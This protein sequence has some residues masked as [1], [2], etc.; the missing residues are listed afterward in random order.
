MYS[1]CILKSDMTGRFYTGSGE[2]L[3]ERLEASQRPPLQGPK[4]HLPSLGLPR[5]GL[6]VNQCFNTN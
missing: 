4:S 5:I 2:E 3:A 1:V 6:S